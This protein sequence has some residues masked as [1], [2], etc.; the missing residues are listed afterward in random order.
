MKKLTI[1]R[2]SSGSKDEIKRTE[3][4]NVKTAPIPQVY[5]VRK[6]RKNSKKTDIHNQWIAEYSE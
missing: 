3:K 6:C 2:K 5:A 4:S 1:S